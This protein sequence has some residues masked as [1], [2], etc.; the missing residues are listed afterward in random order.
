M[1]FIFKPH[2]N[3]KV[4][5]TN[6]ASEMAEATMYANTESP[7]QTNRAGRTALPSPVFCSHTAHADRITCLCRK[8]ASPRFNYVTG[9]QATTYVFNHRGNSYFTVYQRNIR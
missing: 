6:K 1:D 5:E 9:T 8:R 2:A 7:A 3:Q 4:R